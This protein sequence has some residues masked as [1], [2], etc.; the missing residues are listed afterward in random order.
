M[1]VASRSIRIRRSESWVIARAVASGQKNYKPSWAIARNF[2]CAPCKPL[3][4]FKFEALSTR[5]FESRPVGTM[6][7]LT[8]VAQVSDFS[9]KADAPRRSVTILVGIEASSRTGVVNYDSFGHMA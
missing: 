9:A 7:K 1:G 6:S 5:S 3:K 8:S 2:E 4:L